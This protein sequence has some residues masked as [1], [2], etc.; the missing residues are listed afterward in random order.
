MVTK[1]DYFLVSII[2]IL[3]GL[4]AL[5]ILKNIKLFSGGISAGKAALIVFAVFVFANFALWVASLLAKWI[6]VLL[7]IAKFAAI[8]AL[9]TFL[10]LGV[11]NILILFTGA[12]VGYQYTLFKGIS[13]A[14]ATVN[15][16]FWNKHWT[17]GS[18][19][20]ANAKEFAQFFAVSVIGL[21]FNLGAASL[22]VN[23]FGAPSGISPEL[24]ANIGAVS[25]TLVSLVWNFVGYKVVVFKKK[26]II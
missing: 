10:D 16:Y 18:Q 9:N 17:F 24:W 20:S 1:K 5:P 7:Q 2:G 6:P 3:F 8:G 15:S 25:A 23:Y 22:V 4:L 19:D 12:A 11:L 26:E 21:G 14:V 13:F